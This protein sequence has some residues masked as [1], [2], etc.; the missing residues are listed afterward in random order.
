M[1]DENGLEIAQ[2][3][4]AAKVGENQPDAVHDLSKDE[5][6]E[7]RRRLAAIRS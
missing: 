6:E 7:L 3:L 2:Q 5:D 4:D 1:A